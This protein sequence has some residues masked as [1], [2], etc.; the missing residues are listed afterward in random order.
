MEGLT[1]I[2]KRCRTV[3]PR[4]V[5]HRF[6]NI[7]IALFSIIYV[8]ICNAAIQSEYHFRIEDSTFDSIARLV[9]TNEVNRANDTQVAGWIGKMKDIASRSGNPVLDARSTLWQIR[10][11]QLNANPDSCI[12]L[13]EKARGRIPKSYDYD[14]ACLSYQLAGNHDRIGNYFNT[15]QLLQEAIP[16]FEKYGDD[17]FLGNARLLLGLMYSSIGDYDQ[18]LEEINLAERHY[19]AYGYPNNRIAYFKATL[20][21]DESEKI[22]LYKEAIEQGS[23]D[24]GMTIQAYEQLATIYNIRNE[25][26]SA[27]YYLSLGENMRAEM[28]PDNLL[29]KIVLNIQEAEVL[30]SRGEYDKALALLEETETIALHY[31]NEYW[32]PSIYK[33]MARIYENKGNRQQAFTY[34]KKYLKAYERQVNTFRGQEVPKAKAREAIQ[35]QKELIANMEQEAKNAHNRFIIILLVLIAVI[36]LAGAIF[37]YFYQR[38][39]MRRL[40]NRELRTNL[41]QEMII[42]RLNLENFERDIKQKDCE[43]SS[44]V[45]LLSNKNDVLQQI[46]V[47]TKK[48]SDEGRIP[49]EFVDQVNSLVSDSLRGDDEWSRFKIHFDSVHPDFF[50]KLKKASD[51]LTENDLRLCAYIKIGMRAKD[52]ASMLSVSPASVNTNRYRIRRKLNLSKEDSLDDYIRKI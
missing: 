24:P 31:P 44:S 11:T 32:E 20:A 36:I 7:A 3:I 5:G 47:I 16:I 6:K 29:L 49:Y 25:S 50:T 51:E 12:A 48:Y 4:S 15:Y 40:E 28:V 46:R 43:I 10:S 22:H 9:L 39:K 18:A 14:Y 30:Y 38:M 35:R 26:D 42:K 34:L 33:Y 45:L 52:I 8:H 27:M 2:L 21:K 17:Y 41:E 37:L 1:Y 13:L 19:S 23:D